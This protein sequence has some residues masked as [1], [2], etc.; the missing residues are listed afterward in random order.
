ML[1]R[2]ECRFTLYLPRRIL[3][4]RNPQCNAE[5][6]VK[7]LSFSQIDCVHK[8][9]R[10]L[11]IFLLLSVF[12]FTNQRTYSISFVMKLTTEIMISFFSVFYKTENLGNSKCYAEAREYCFFAVL[13][14]F[15]C[16]NN[17]E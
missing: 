10:N 4:H 3:S 16:R 14:K 7:F 8:W 1:L 13:L 12:L 5:C 17:K 15:L 6:H 11:L 2:G 9:N